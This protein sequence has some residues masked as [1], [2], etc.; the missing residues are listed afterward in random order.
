MSSRFGPKMG[1]LSSAYFFRNLDT[2]FSLSN[3]N[4]R[5][6]V[7]RRSSK[8]VLRSLPVFLWLISQSS[9]Q[10]KLFTVDSMRR[11]NTPS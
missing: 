7:S 3:D 4:R 10:E 11:P 9:F 8:M 6:E 2:L 1:N 5:S